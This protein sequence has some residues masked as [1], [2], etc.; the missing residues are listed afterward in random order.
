MRLGRNAD[1]AP[2][3][4]HG[5][6]AVQR[7]PWPPSF[8]DIHIGWTFLAQAKHTDMQVEL[9][10]GLCRLDYSCP[11]EFVEVAAVASLQDLGTPAGRLRKPSPQCA[12]A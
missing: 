9:F 10:I 12:V 3:L 1:S 7:L 11:F 8:T 4:G 6:L 5:D 2:L